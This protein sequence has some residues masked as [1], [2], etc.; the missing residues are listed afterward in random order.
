MEDKNNIPESN[1]MKVIRGTGDTVEA[2]EVSHLGEKKVGRLENFWYHH[3]WHAGIIIGAVIIAAVFII[4]ALSHK[5]PDVYIMYAGPGSMVGRQYEKFEETVK[6][7]MDD[8]DKNGYCAISFTDNTYL[9]KEQIDARRKMG[10]NIDVNANSAAYERFQM[11]IGSGEHMLCML[12]PAL[13]EEVKAVQGF[14]PLTE[15]FGDMPKGAVDEYGI[16]LGDTEFYKSNPDIGFL[17]ADTVLAMRVKPHLSF[18]TEE[19]L[20]AYEERHHQL[21]RDIVNFVP[22][23]Q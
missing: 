15:V 9:T 14:V 5:T 16:R 4:Q 3:K 8:Y 20:D 10:L 19:K 6:S 11:E 18:K 22:E 7:V 13:Y 12:D 2:K 1:A 17:P 23:E 21:L